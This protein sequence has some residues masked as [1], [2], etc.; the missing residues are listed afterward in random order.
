MMDLDDFKTINDRHGHLVGDA[1]LRH[2]AQVLTGSV[3]REDVAARYGG[4][5]FAI[6]LPDRTSAQAKPIAERIRRAVE[7]ARI[8][9]EGGGPAATVTLSVGV[10]SF[11]EDG[12]DH[13]LIL[14]KADLALY[15]AKRAGKDQVRESGAEPTAPQR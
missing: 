12:E 4:E 14:E 7:G 1:V 9:P 3:R 2:V 6:Y 5:E 13:H 11:P 15:E 10:A 8:E